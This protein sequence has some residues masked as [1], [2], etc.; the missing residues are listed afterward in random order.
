LAINFITH[1]RANIFDILKPEEWYKAYNQWVRIVANTKGI[2]SYIFQQPTLKKTVTRT[3][4]GHWR[5]IWFTTLKTQFTVAVH[6][7]IYSKFWCHLNIYIA[8]HSLQP[9]SIRQPIRL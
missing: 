4:H 7:G 3:R 1:N 2:Q 6:S 5:S 8:A 9:L